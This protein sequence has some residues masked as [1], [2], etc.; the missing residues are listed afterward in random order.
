MCD[1]PTYDHAPDGAITT[2]GAAKAIGKSEG[3]IR[4]LACAGDLVT[5][6][7]LKDGTGGRPSRLVS[8]ASVEARKAG[9]SRDNP[10]PVGSVDVEGAATILGLTADYVRDLAARGE[11]RT[12]A[13]WKAPTAR[14]KRRMLSLADVRAR[15]AN[16]PTVGAHRP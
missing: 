11:I 12:V 15:L 13:W 16:P 9:R 3:H 14:R 8:I 7:W 1:A 4:R 10:A 5:V 6:G 2:A